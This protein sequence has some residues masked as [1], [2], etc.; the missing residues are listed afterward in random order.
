MFLRSPQYRSSSKLL[1]FAPF[2]LYCSN[3]VLPGDI[4]P[5]SNVA[6]GCA[7]T[8][9]TKWAPHPVPITRPVLR[10][11]VPQNPLIQIPQLKPTRHKPKPRQLLRAPRLTRPHRFAHDVLHPQQYLMPIC[12]G[13]TPVLAKWVRGQGKRWPWWRE[14]RRRLACTLYM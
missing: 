12:T 6:L 13:D 1:P 4:L 2:P 14:A 7:N 10:G 5:S 11:R 9:I 3:G 8:E